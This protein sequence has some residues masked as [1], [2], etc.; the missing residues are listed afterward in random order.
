M[1]AQPQQQSIPDAPKPQTLPDLRTITPPAPAT[2]ETP[3]E[4][5]AQADDK[6][7]QKAPGTSLPATTVQSQEPDDNEGAPPPPKDRNSY[8]LR[9]VEVNLVEV[10]FIVKDSKGAQVP[11]LTWRDVRVYENNSRQGIAFMTSDPFPLS[12]AIVIDQSVTDDTM[13]RINTAL[14]A[15]QGAFSP[16]DEIAIYTYNNGVTQRT[17]FTGAQSSRAAYAIELS[18]GRGRD[19][20]M[21]L[22]GP[23][24]VGISKNGNPIDPNT[25]GRRPGAV[26]AFEKPEKEFHTLY[27]AVLAAATQTT[28]AD[29]GRRR[30]VYVIS[31]GKEYGSKAKQNEVVKYCLTNKVAVWGTLVGDSSLPVLGFLDRIH[32]PY[33]MR[34]NAL[35]H[36]VNAT[37]GQLDAEFSRAGIE[38]SFE[39]IA[40]EARN[41]Y[42]LAY[43]S[44]E[45]L[46]DGKYRKIDIHVMRPGLQVI[47][48][49]GYWPTAAD[50]RRGAPAPV[51]TV[52]PVAIPVAPAPATK[53]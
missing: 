38:K 49:D 21:P 8:V 30:I 10:P 41:E 31:D 2:P 12:V 24:S 4:T 6:F 11:G 51:R 40:S 29:R 48:K 1:F 19:P 28:K 7:Q 15:L 14:G 45:P 44:H 25:T 43:Y 52:A 32:L 42:T 5:P 26:T 46:I 36:L 34:D 3:A 53:Q 23:L 33:T 27:D 47:A 37:A 39:R 16:Y 50:S 17:E 18:K 20:L 22:G 9:P 35:T 13:A